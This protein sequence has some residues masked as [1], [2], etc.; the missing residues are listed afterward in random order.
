MY[1]C[2]SWTIT[3]YYFKS[4]RLEKLLANR[5]ELDGCHYFDPQGVR[6]LD[7]EGFNN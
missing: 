6:D 4:S 5:N 1:N 7:G 2:N 3:I